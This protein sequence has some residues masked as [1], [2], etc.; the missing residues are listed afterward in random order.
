M[1]TL[2]LLKPVVWN[3]KGYR[4][5]SG[6]GSQ[7]SHPATHGFG[8]EEWNNAPQ[9]LGVH[10][11]RPVK[12][13]HTEGVGRA[14]VDDHRG[15]VIVFLIAAHD[16]GQDLVGVGGRAEALFASP[17]RTAIADTLGLAALADEV[18]ALPDARAV[19]GGRRA[20]FQAYWDE[21]VSWIPT[22]RSPAT[23]WF[24][25]DRPVRL[26]PEKI[27][28]QS[29]L[30]SRYTTYSSLNV[31]QAAAIMTSVP[32]AQRS[33]AWRGIWADIT[34]DPDEIRTDIEAVEA[35]G[36]RSRTVRQQLIDARLGQGRY[37]SQLDN[38]W[39]GAC[40]VTG[41][42]VREALRASHMKAWSIS[43]DRERL[44]PANG[45]LLVATL[46][47]LFDRG[48]ISFQDDG[49]M[50]VSKRL[51]RADRKALGLPGSLS[52]PPE[53][54]EL[55]YLRHHRERFFLRD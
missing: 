23:H 11:Q 46:D 6:Y 21:N 26:N 51:T 15:D 7:D 54:D 31:E 53:Q 39:D 13:F 52:R 9:M 50:I 42:S 22:W 18:W 48:L 8:H 55:P 44:D 25:P 29:R 38:R 30:V 12:Y 20:D 14:P 3:T 35:D 28:G 43:T 47:C 40:S 41:C 33:D 17:E 4:G 32:D 45:L 24:A 16:G 1:V 2:Y 36:R 27:T 5:P 19:W 10:N 49:R 37:R 34:R